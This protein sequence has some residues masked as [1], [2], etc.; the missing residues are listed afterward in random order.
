MVDAARYTSELGHASAMTPDWELLAYLRES[1]RRAMANW[2][3]RN[4]DAVGR[5]STIDLAE[6]F[7]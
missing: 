1:G 3:G 2:L 7:L 6:K 4:R 5:H